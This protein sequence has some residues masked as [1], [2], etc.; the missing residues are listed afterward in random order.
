MFPDINLIVS[1]SFDKVNPSIKFNWV[2][3]DKLPWSGEEYLLQLVKE[4][5]FKDYNTIVFCETQKIWDR[6]SALLFENEIPNL[7][8]Y[9]GMESDLRLETLHQLYLGKWRVIVSTNLLSRGIDKLNY[10]IELIIININYQIF[11]FYF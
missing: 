5:F 7:P 8:Y 3:V 6:I 1:N 9:T 10:V 4:D 2:D 11:I